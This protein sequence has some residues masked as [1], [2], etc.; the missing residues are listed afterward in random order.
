[1]YLLDT[2]VFVTAYR[3]H[4]GFDFHPGFWEW[5][6]HANRVGRVFSVDKVYKEIRRSEDRLSRWVHARKDE[7]F[8]EPPVD[9]N[10][11]LR[12]IVDYLRSENYNSVAIDQFSDSADSYLIAHALSNNFKIVTHEVHK[13]SKGKIK[14]PSVCERLNVECITPFD[15]LRQ[16]GARFIWQPKYD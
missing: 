3:F 14:I 2:N 5:L 16:E 10:Y 15:M 12:S 1:M 8:L 9:S 7:L 4:Y 13:S 6:I 11:H